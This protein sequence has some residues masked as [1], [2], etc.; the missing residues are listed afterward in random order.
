M[1]SHRPRHN[2]FPQTTW[3]SVSIDF[4]GPFPSGE[5][6][7]VVIDDYSRFPE[8]EIVRSISADTIIPRLDSVFATHGIPDVVKSDNGPKFTGH[9]FAA[10][11]KGFH[12]RK[13][14][15]IWLAANGEVERFM[16][17]LK[18]AIVEERCPAVSTPV[19][20]NATCDNM[21]VA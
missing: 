1:S 16:R 21:E 15:P 17:T 7:M 19:P 20:S 8:I 14:T 2:E 18:K 9:Q 10:Y 4:C 3:S 13:I 5:H 6:V 12:H 11:A